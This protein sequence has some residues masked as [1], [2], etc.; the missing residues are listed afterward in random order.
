MLVKWLTCIFK[1]FGRLV[2]K[3][4]FIFYITLFINNVWR[5]IMGYNDAIALSTNNVWRLI[6]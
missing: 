4:I 1:G 2:T 3:N 5:L 6:I